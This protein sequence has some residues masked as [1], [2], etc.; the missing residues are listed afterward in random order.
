MRPQ[1][2]LTMHLPQQ[3]RRRSATPGPRQACRGC[4]EPQ[5]QQPH[6]HHYRSPDSPSPIFLPDPIFLAAPI[7]LAVQRPVLR[8]RAESILSSSVTLTVSPGALAIARRIS[9]F[10]GSLCL[11]SPNAI[12]ELWNGNPSMVPFTFTSPRVPKKAADLGQMT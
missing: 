10:T 7:F 1:G 2:P 6:R 8:L 12:N 11:P 9:A 3:Q 4:E 5:P